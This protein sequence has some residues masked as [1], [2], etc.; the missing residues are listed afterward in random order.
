MFLR[1]SKSKTL[2]RIKLIEWFNSIDS[3]S[4]ERVFLKRKSMYI[5][6]AGF[7]MKMGL[8]SI[9][10]RQHIVCTWHYIHK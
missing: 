1:N 5:V 7:V 3:R 4:A 8:K 10:I 2:Y 6:G 9:M